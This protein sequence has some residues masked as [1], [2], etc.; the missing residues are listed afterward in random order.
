MTTPLVDPAP[1][2]ALWDTLLHLTP[3][4]ILLFDRAL[5]CRYAAPAAEAF[6]G[7]PP[8]QLVGQPAA[9]IFP[10]AANG[11]KSVM[12]RVAELA[13]STVW[14][15]PRY[16]F[17]CAVDG[18]NTA[19]CSDIHISPVWVGDYRGVVVML[20][21]SREI[22]TVNAERERLASEVSSLRTALHDVRVQLRNRLTP[23]MGYLQLFARRP[24]VLGYRSDP[25]TIADVLLPMLMHVVAA[26][27]QL[28]TAVPAARIAPL[29]APPDE[30]R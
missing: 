30:P 22:H 10:P 8:D 27:D 7:R 25:A 6:L 2:D 23:V 15:H 17:D 3:V 28:V 20:S 14:L 9:A 13:G 11:L 18:I 16:Q 4:D 12:E 21:D 5:I 24:R 29:A 19:F 1:P 26:V